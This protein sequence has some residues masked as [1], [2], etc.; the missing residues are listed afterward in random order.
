MPIDIAMRVYQKNKTFYDK[1]LKNKSLMDAE[2]A[3]KA[4]VLLISGCQDDQ[5]SEDGDAN[6]LFISQLKFVWNHGSF[7]KN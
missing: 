5:L 1:I 6:G 2:D 4:S 7:K 3:V